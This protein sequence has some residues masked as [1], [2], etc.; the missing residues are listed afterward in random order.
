MI[1]G[2]VRVPASFDLEYEHSC[3]KADVG[4]TSCRSRENIRHVN[5]ARPFWNECFISKYGM[6]T[7]VATHTTTI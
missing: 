6:D 3:K 4:V 5:N 1:L 7:L 2:T